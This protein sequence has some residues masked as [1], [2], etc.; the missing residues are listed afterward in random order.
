MKVKRLL[1]CHLLVTGMFS[2]MAAAAPRLPG[3]ETLLAFSRK[4]LAFGGGA[5]LWLCRSFGVAHQHDCPVAPFAALGEG[6]EP[7]EQYW[8]HA[9]PVHFQ[10][11]RD[12]IILAD[13]VPFDLTMEEAEPLIAALNQHFIADGL[14][15]FAPHAN[16]WYLRLNTVP[17]MRTHPLAEV[18]GQNVDRLL[19]QGADAMRWNSWLN[20]VQMLLHE[21]PVNQDR[22]Q[23]GNFPVNSVW[24]WGGGVLSRL[25]SLPFRDVWTENALGCGLVKASGGKARSL[26][27]SAWEWFDQTPADGT[28]LV[29]LN[30]LE[31]ADLREDAVNWRETLE[32]LERHWFVPLLENLRQGQLVSIHLHLSGLH[33]VRSFSVGRDNLWKFWRKPKPLERYL[34]D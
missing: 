15:F 22:E 32:R 2:E 17:D 23:R 27:F 12:H 6:L 13:C 20:E 5:D 31:K 3:L 26:P 28:H 16:R 18:I 24:P 1:H 9:D 8:L 4:S 21:H 10:L 29:M 19:P 14:Q 33:Q 25:E 34:N 30:D 7:G 11:L